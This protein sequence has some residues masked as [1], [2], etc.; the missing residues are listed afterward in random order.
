MN[1]QQQI[2]E[3][4]REHQNIK[5]IPHPDFPKDSFPATLSL[6]YSLRDLNKNVNLIPEKY[7]QKFSFLIRENFYAQGNFLVSVDQKD[8]N[9]SRIFYQKNEDSLQLYLK[10]KKGNIK[11][12]DIELFP[13]NPSSLALSLGISDFD[14]LNLFADEKIKKRNVINIDNKENNKKYGRVNLIK[15]SSFSELS[16]DLLTSIK[17][18]QDK[19]TIDSLLAGMT[20]HIF[21]P[22]SPLQ[23][24]TIRKMATLIEKTNFERISKELHIF[25]EK[26]K[27][28]L[29]KKSLEK[30]KIN[31]KLRFNTLNLTEKDFKETETNSSLLPWIFKKLVKEM[32]PKKTFLC[33]FKPFS[34][35]KQAFFSSP[36]EKVLKEVST[37]F[38]GKVKR[39]KLIFYPQRNLQQT[40]EK[41]KEIIKTH[42]C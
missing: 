27:M 13:L 24:K 4:I 8:S 35:Q 40:K 39:K 7:P 3:K 2:K 31:K 23:I 32:F 12:E 26:P 30:L 42:G 22:Q 17:N 41:I 21:H 37:L 15:P 18:I 16:F 9:I 14:Q 20:E 33:F 28:R 11:K 1:N 25:P 29:F 10:T 5:L 6:F 38:D 36:Y 19:D 34:S